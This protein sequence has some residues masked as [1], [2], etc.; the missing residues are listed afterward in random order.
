MRRYGTC[1]P[2]ELSG[3]PLFSS[4]GPVRCGVRHP[5]PQRSLAAA[6]HRC[7][8]IGLLI[9]W[10]LVND[11]CAQAETLR[12]VYPRPESHQDA[13]TRYPIALLQ[14]AL[15]KAALSY[16]LAPSAVYMPQSRSLR[17]LAAGRLDV[18]WT[19]T[20]AEREQHLLP[21]RI[22][23]DRGL[24]GWRLLLVHRDRNAAFAAINTVAALAPF[25]AGQGHDWPDVGILRSNGLAVATST[26]YEGLFQMLSRGH[27]DYFPRGLSE[28]DNELAARPQLPLQIQS[29]LVLHYPTA[30]YFFVQPDN[31]RLAEVL[32]TGLQRAQADGSWQQLFEQTYGATIAH[33]AIGKRRVLS[34]R[35]PDL[36]VTT[37]LADHRWWWQPDAR[38]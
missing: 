37:P 2:F 33:A 36:P 24:I 21:V 7:W 38:H 31:R 18:V 4:S 10:L 1:S 12:V 35:N 9:A 25:R 6:G 17:E 28:I 5:A 11:N 23:I 30:L 13:R 8:Q 19:V 14:L 3:M 32:N 29:D 16:R 26:R 34:L 27:I 22:P 15:D 20:S